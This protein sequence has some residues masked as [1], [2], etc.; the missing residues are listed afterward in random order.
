MADQTRTTAP[1]DG[2]DPASQATLQP[3][4]Q[5]IKTRAPIPEAKVPTGRPYAIPLK[6]R[7]VPQLRLIY[8]AS[9]GRRPWGAARR[10][11]CVC[12]TTAGE[13]SACSPVSTAASCLASGR[14]RRLSAAQREK[15]WPG[16]WWGSTA[17]GQWTRSPSNSPRLPPVAARG[18]LRHGT[19]MKPVGGLNPAVVVRVFVAKARPSSSF[20]VRKVCAWR[21]L[22]RRASTA[23]AV[24]PLSQ[25]SDLGPWNQRHQPV[26]RELIP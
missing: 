5:N 20:P 3:Y 10:V 8:S 25:P 18:D 16:Q 22:S 11:R 1:G 4:R 21:G 2:A 6:K 26:S 24:G 14:S 9:S 12:S 19:E 13:L 23:L 15:S 17:R 7:R